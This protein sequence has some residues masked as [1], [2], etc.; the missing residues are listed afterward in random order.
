[1][2]DADKKKAAQPDES[3][4]QAVERDAF[5]N[6]IEAGPPPL[7]KDLAPEEPADEPKKEVPPDLVPAESDEP[8]ESEPEDESEPADAD[9]APTDEQPMP[10][11]EQDQDIESEDTPFDDEKTG[12]AIEEIVAKEGDEI[13]AAQDAAAAKGKVDAPRQKRGF[14]RRKWVRWTIMLLV[15]SG[16]TAAGV[17]P[18][19]RYW[20]LNTAG[21]R[22][23]SS[24]VVVDSTTQL[25]LKG[26]EVTLA[27]MTAHTDSAG[28]VSFQDLKLGATELSIYRVGFERLQQK[29]TLGWG[30]NPLG[31]FA[32]NATGVQYVIQVT[33]YVS[34]QPLEGVEATNGAATAISDKD[35]KITLTLEN[36]AVAEG[37]V[38]LSKAGY[39][40]EAIT[41]PE[42]PTQP[43]E[44][45]LVMA[46]K[47]VFV[48]RQ[49][50]RYN[51]YKSDIDGKNRETLLAATGNENSNITLAVSQDG[52][53]AALISTR[54]GKR[55]S[56]GFV[57]SSLVLIDVEQ[58]S[59]VTIAEAAQIQ[60]IDWVGTRLVYQLGASDSSADDRYVVAS[61]DYANSIRVQLAAANKL[62]AVISALGSVYYAPAANASSEGVGLFKIG[63]DGKNKQKVH[64][65]EEVISVLRSAYGT[66]SLQMADGTWA[67]YDM[68][69]GNKTQTGTPASLASRLYID[70]NGRTQSLWANQ[71]TLRLYDVAAAK[72]S[73]VATLT[74]LTYPLQWADDAAAIV[75][76]SNATE[77]A[78]YIVSTAGGT[79]RKIADV[80]PTY[81]FSQAQ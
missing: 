60:L 43:T 23:S 45:E 64:D 15:L 44:A 75:R 25:P 56:G 10:E 9:D 51:L 5:G 76:V 4:E 80:T 54:D 59:T 18:T 41:L 3:E 12:K 30:S 74:G 50:N 29:V 42:D 61:Y 55:D 8:E 73:D 20:M 62:Q 11:A 36:T 1:M 37:G 68:V 71:G 14:W 39:R 34:G 72:D 40:S 66:L 48:S 67:S 26:V 32:L 16:I 22:S 28:E 21:V 58:G 2:P 77:T 13:L 79:P 63:L 53:H 70:N 31:R 35:G 65:G 52:S 33:D 49:D 47:A 6:E 24:V 57:L 38:A 7:A 69:S 19:S 81:G 17:V 78:D 46:R 27:G